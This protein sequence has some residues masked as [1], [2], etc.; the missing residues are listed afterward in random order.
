MRTF[1]ITLPEAKERQTYITE[2]MGKFGLEFEFFDAVDGRPLKPDSYPAY[3]KTRRH[4]YFGKDMTGGEIGVLSS[5]KAIYEKMINEGIEIALIMEDDA[6]LF[7]DF[8]TVFNALEA[9]PHDFDCVRFLGSEKVANHTQY[10]KRSINNQ[11]SLNRIAATPGGAHAYILTLAGAAKLLRQMDK[12]YLPIDTLLGYG[13]KTGLDAYVVQPG[14]ARQDREQPQYIGN[15]RF[16][17]SLQRRGLVKYLYPLTRAW[18]KMTEGLL[19]RGYYYK[20]FLQ[21]KYL[22]EN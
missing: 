13:W 16:D 22:R 17:K 2:M 3:D 7:D 10:T 19:K 11:Y 12:N 14:L 18:H 15:A 21:D 6:L 9:G 1:V 5:H 8:A 4:L 20:S